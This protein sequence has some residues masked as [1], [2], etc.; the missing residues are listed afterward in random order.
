MAFLINTSYIFNDLLK[1]QT[2][3][4]NGILNTSYFQLFQ[5]SA[6]E[7]P[8][9]K[10]RSPASFALSVLSLSSINSEL[11]RLMLMVENKAGSQ[12]TH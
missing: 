7:Q 3:K 11:S 1:K 5:M 6:A 9:L 4:I 8:I 10:K 12:V 2:P